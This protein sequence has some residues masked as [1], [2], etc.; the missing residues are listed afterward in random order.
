MLLEQYTKFG[1]NAG[2]TLD[3]QK[4]AERSHSLSVEV[5]RLNTMASSHMHIAQQPPASISRGKPLHEL[6]P[7]QARRK[8]AAH[9]LKENVEHAL[10]GALQS[11]GLQ[12]VS[13]TLV[14][15]SNPSTHISFSWDEKLPARSQ[16]TCMQYEE[17]T[18]LKV[19]RKR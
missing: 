19:L 4:I 9:A 12:P 3:I 1:V 5:K 13:V 17:S 8:K 14:D 18:I 10:L 16:A 2:E 15:E 7:R 6:S 11:L